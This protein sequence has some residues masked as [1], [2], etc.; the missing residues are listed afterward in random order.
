[1]EYGFFEILQLIGSLGLFL[2]GMEL[3]SE[4]LQKTAGSKLRSIMS[5]MTSNRIM[6]IL[7]GVFVTAVIQSSSATTVM[8]VSFVNAGLMSLVQSISVIMGANIGTT[9]TAWIISTFGFKVNISDFSI[10]IIAIAFPLIFSKRNSRKNWGQLLI[11]FALLFMGLDLLKHS[12]PDIKSSPEM[13]SFLSSYTDLGFLSTLLF[14]FIGSV[15]TIVVQSSSATMAITLI[16]C[17]QGWITYEIAAA[18]V[19]GENIGTTITANLAALSANISAKRTA[20]A[21]SVFNL[22]GVVWVLILFTPFTSFA[23]SIVVG[24][25]VTDT[26]SLNAFS[27]SLFHT[28]FNI[29]NVLLLGWF[30]VPIANLVTK[31]VKQK[32]TDEEFKLT[33][34][35]TGLLSTS[36]LSV[37]QAQKEIE[38]YAERVQKMFGLV[39]EYYAEKHSNKQVKLF[40][41][42]TKYENISDRMELEIAAYLTELTSG[43]LGDESKT[44]V[45]KMLRM[46]SEIES[47][48]DSCHNATRV[49]E[50]GRSEKVKFTTSIDAGLA[51]MFTLID[52]ALIN[53]LRVLTLM[54]DEQI[55]ISRSQNLEDE[56]NYCR[57][58]LKINNV[59]DVKNATYQYN[60]SI[61]YMDMIVELE[62]MG[63]YIIN[64]VEVAAEAKE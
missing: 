7:T 16:M 35:S 22:F 21:H 56:I 39:K 48:A 28:I 40:S 2:F 54:D 17:A 31:L 15:L 14:L 10:P 29:S 60:T 37:L 19:L 44:K 20:L 8:L 9:V 46:I 55:D 45:H 6:G 52:D 57:N 13:L 23:R 18:M 33:H 59:S 50:R 5:A 62:K 42:I 47:L 11:G 53:M 30:A 38:A 61:I 43:Q 1:M 41:R 58:Q 27:L 63:D 24:S 49:I 51:Q 4:A 25:G 32:N 36:E 12:V 64:I 34:I 3:M 26:M